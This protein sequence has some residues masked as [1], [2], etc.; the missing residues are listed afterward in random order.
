MNRIR[1]KVTG[2]SGMG[3]LSLG[4]I[5]AKAL[6]EHGFYVNADREYPSLIKGGHSSL[7]V[8]FSSQPIHS[9]SR[10]ADL[11]IAL[12]QPGLM[13]HLDTVKS[14]GVILH[15]SDR[16]SQIKGLNEEAK[17]RKL[18]LV[19]C[20]ARDIA[21]SFGGTEVMV[22]MV[23]LGVLWKALGLKLPALEAEIR[24]QF[25]SKPKLLEIDLKCVRAG[26]QWEGIRAISVPQLPHPA[27]KPRQLLLDGNM[28]LTLGAIHAGVRAYFA[29]PMSPMSS[30]LTSMADFSKEMGLLIKQAEDEITAAQMCVGA[31]FMGTRAFTT[32]SGG[33]F[34]L[35]TETVSLAGMTE[36]PLVVAI[37]QRPGPA[38][39]LP[40]WSSQGD[41]NLA[42]HAGHGEYPRVVV[43]CADPASCFELIQHAFNLAE[44]FQTPV[45]VLTEKTIA[46]T[47]AMTDVFKLKK[48]PIKRGLVTGADALA[49]LTSQD[50]YRLTPTGVSLRWI[51]GSSSVVYCANGDEHEEDG[52]LTESA[53]PVA[54]MMEKRMRK[55]ETIS[56][57]FPE[58]QLFGP[59][60]GAA[61]SFVGWGSSKNAM[62]DV[63]SQNKGGK[64]NYL[65]FDYLYP[66]KTKTLRQFWSENKNVHLI[67]G[68]FEGQFGRL[69]EG[70]TGL[71]FKGKLLKYNGRPFFVEDVMEYITQCHP[72]E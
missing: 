25:A 36:T 43:A 70:E 9:L 61:I 28:A 12:D 56:N 37:G 1:I 42:L 18:Q 62:R 59:K 17:K 7:Q 45:I 69:I 22:N 6:K 2:E 40:T 64:I 35:M 16:F 20:P 52:T 39:G 60:K 29:Y 67:E 19:Y 23:L 49:K 4:R 10:Q 27:K 33:G 30:V 65:H 41:F 44:E 11:M 3:L 72:S 8:D 54:R 15:R 46:E 55:L 53:E 47:H 26:Y 68:N 71:K 63:I 32:T 34:D 14:G 51:P 58:P 31:M 24:H 50:R 5:A 57:A 13:G 21:R 66:L 48:I 38:T